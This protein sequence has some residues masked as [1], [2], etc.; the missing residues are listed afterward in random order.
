MHGTVT[1]RGLTSAQA[2]PRSRQGTN[3]RQVSS[4]NREVRHHISAV[5]DVGIPR[6]EAQVYLLPGAPQ[7]TATRSA[8][9]WS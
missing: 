9:C 3:L 6:D 4:P 1:G 2:A 8:A 5:R 7:T